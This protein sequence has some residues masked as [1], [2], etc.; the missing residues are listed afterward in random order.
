MGIILTQCGKGEES[1]NENRSEK[2]HAL[3]PVRLFWNRWPYCEVGENKWAVM[4]DRIIGKHDTRVPATVAYA[5]AS[6]IAVDSRFGMGALDGHEG[7]GAQW[8]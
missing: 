8:V 7:A 6:K 4:L 3:A 5:S 2:F 1:T